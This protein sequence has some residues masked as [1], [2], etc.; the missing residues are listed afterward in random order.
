[1]S[2][3]NAE[4]QYTQP[5]TPRNGGTVFTAPPHQAT[6]DFAV[7]AADVAAD[8][9]R[10][11]DLVGRARNIRAY[12]LLIFFILAVLLALCLV[13]TQVVLSET[14]DGASD[15]PTSLGNAFSFAR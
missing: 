4:P 11:L 9:G 10:G 1:M 3:R 5:P 8:F 6:G 15:E 13:G 7:G 2:V 14:S 12:E